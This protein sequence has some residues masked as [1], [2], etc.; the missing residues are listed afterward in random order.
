MNIRLATP[1]DKQRVLSLLN[2][3]G[4][5]NNERVPYSYDSKYEKAE[6]FG[7]SNYDTVMKMDDIKIFVIEDNDIIIGVAS[8]FIMTDMIN[9]EKFAHIDDFIIDESHRRKGYGRKLMSGILKYAKVHEIGT[10]KLTS[11]LELIEAHAFYEIIGG[12]FRQK[13]ISFDV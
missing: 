3:L 2:Q 6:I 13:G 1:L 7:S 12:K 8:F 5:I 9:G 11:A 4:K 10:V